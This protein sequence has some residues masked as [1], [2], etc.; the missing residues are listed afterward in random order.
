VINVNLPTLAAIL[1]L[2]TTNAGPDAPPLHCFAT[3]M[4]TI[5]VPCAAE[6]RKDGRP[7]ATVSAEAIALFD[8]GEG[9]R[10]KLP[11][12]IRVDD[13]RGTTAIAE[14]SLRSA[15]SPR[16]WRIRMPLSALR[17]LRSL[18]VP[19]DEYDVTV[20][21]DGYTSIVSRLAGDESKLTGELR[22]IPRLVGRVLDESGNPL[23]ARAE[24]Q[25]GKLL[26]D[27]GVDG[28]FR[29]HLPTD[30]REKTIIVRSPGHASRAVR[31]TRRDPDVD[32]GEVRLAKG[33]TLT[34]EI[35]RLD[36]DEPIEVSVAQREE[37][38]VSTLARKT[39]APNEE[40][41]RFADLAAGEYSLVLAGKGPL[42]RLATPIA[43]TDESPIAVVLESRDLDGAVVRGERSVGEVELTI[44]D[45][46]GWWKTSLRT[47]VD[48]KFQERIWNDEE[49]SVTVTSSSLTRPLT[50]RRSRP[51]CLTSSCRWEIRVPVISVS[52]QITDAANGEALSGATLT[53]RHA[54]A[55]SAGVQG[56]RTD[57]AGRYSIDPL[58]PGSYVLEASAPG[59]SSERWPLT[60]VEREGEQRLTADLALR[61]TTETQLEVIGAN[62]MPA[63]GA[64]VELEDANG[65]TVQRFGQTAPVG[66]AD[67]AG[68]VP[69]SG[70]PGQA[71]LA[72]A[73]PR[74]GSLGVAR[75]EIPTSPDRPLRMGVA[76]AVARIEVTTVD[77][78]GKPAPAFLLL[79]YNGIVIPPDF[80]ASLSPPLVLETD[81]NG[82]VVLNGLPAGQ[83]QI[84]AWKTLAHLAAA[85]NGGGSPTT[86]VAG[87]GARAATVRLPEA[88]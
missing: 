72:F 20:S 74:E 13:R 28:S 18:E 49:V 57:H 34:V 4:G 44:S 43:L 25:D 17:S 75:V 14:L 32:L 77:G 68:R 12:A 84:Y 2:A 66:T 48:G 11:V 45:L 81:R 71:L 86:V 47:G 67:A 69:V 8:E 9:A 53:I 31:A 61:P 73:A 51:E 78:E 30:F 83:Y 52:G 19:N 56:L 60:V 3:E 63:A 1:I 55:A 76:P 87:A 41:L 38:T 26:G 21:A 42:E 54:D 58:L 85:V 33:L 37:S 39:L 36:R 59:Y 23:P 65:W 79:R 46:D 6:K 29:L 82:T 40:T 64:L 5:D 62:G 70:A 27:A 80:A 50:L 10:R 22:V 35:R 88:N 24:A 15:R 16:A 7:W